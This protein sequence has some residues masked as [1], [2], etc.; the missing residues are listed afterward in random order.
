MWSELQTGT[1]SASCLVPLQ[2]GMGPSIHERTFPGL[3]LC[4]RLWDS[5]RHEQELL[6]TPKDQSLVRE[7]NVLQSGLLQATLLWVRPSAQ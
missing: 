3:T 7:A 5:N 1:H 6:S 2:L 4:A